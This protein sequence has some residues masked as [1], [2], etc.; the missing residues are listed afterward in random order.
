MPL[1]RMFQLTHWVVGISGQLLT[2]N[3]HPLYPVN[4]QD[5]QGHRSTWKLYP[6]IAFSHLVLFSISSIHW[7]IG[8][9]A[10]N[11][12][13]CI[14]LPI[15]CKWKILPKHQKKDFISSKTQDSKNGF[16]PKEQ[17]R[18]YTHFKIWENVL[19]DKSFK[20]SSVFGFWPSGNNK[21]ANTELHLAKYKAWHS[22]AWKTQKMWLECLEQ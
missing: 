9:S 20:T 7:Y 4:Q 12:L 15:Q 3:S 1:L 13:T 5:S 21:D 2:E 6:N 22:N 8:A 10:P 17:E 16:C 18:T 11:S 14:I 19:A